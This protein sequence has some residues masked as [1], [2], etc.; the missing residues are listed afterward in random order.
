MSED[1]LVSPLGPVIH[2]ITDLDHDNLE[3]QFSPSVKSPED[4]GEN[5]V[6]NQETENHE[7]SCPFENSSLNSPINVSSNIE[8]LSILEPLQPK[9]VLALIYKFLLSILIF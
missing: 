9:Y 6:H 8:Q 7:S 2:E 1:K 3:N 4:K 5:N